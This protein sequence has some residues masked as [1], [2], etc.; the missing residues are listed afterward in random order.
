MSRISRHLN[1]PL[2]TPIQGSIMS[3]CLA[4]V[5]ETLVYGKTEFKAELMKIC[6]T[7]DQATNVMQEMVARGLIERQ[8]IITDKAREALQRLKDRP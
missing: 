8:V 3:L 5:A 6:N 1:K 4:R 2:G 7:K